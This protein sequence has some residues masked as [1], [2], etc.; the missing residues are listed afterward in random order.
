MQFAGFLSTNVQIFSKDFAVSI[1][2]ST[3]AMQTGVSEQHLK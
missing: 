1:I 2:L 3:F